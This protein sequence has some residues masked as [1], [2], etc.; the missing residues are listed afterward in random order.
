MS[1]KELIRKAFDDVCVAMVEL[2][3][4]KSKLA[5]LHYK[6]ELV[7]NTRAVLDRV[8]VV[9][10]PSNDSHEAVFIQHA[11]AK[12]ALREALSVANKG[13]IEQGLGTAYNATSEAFSLVHRV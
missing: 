6:A 7:E 10:E 11:K 12:D 5:D 9:Y 3:N 13:T 1:N 2:E 4:V 8:S